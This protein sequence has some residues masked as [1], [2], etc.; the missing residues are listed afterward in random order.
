MKL[1]KF[2]KIINKIG[3]KRNFHIVSIDASSASDRVVF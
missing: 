1:E 2:G 3:E